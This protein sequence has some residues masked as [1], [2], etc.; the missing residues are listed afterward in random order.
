[1]RNVNSA[2]MSLF[3][4]GKT[5]SFGNLK[6]LILLYPKSISHRKYNQHAPSVDKGI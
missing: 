6:F 1:M 3:T 4:G 2:D 5:E